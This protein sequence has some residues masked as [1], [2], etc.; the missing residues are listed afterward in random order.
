MISAMPYPVS[1][2]VAPQLANRN[3]LKTALR[4]ILVIPHL[5]LVGGVGA[6]FALNSSRR[7][8]ISLG[9]ETGQIGRASCRE[10]VYSSV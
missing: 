4:L 9:S 10:R 6:G 8:L 3:R 2:S 7:D 1:M 5:I